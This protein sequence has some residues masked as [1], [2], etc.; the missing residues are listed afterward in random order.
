MLH[1]KN[2]EDQTMKWSR[3]K[4][5]PGL[6]TMNIIHCIQNVLLGTK[7][8][9]G[10]YKYCCVQSSMLEYTVVLVVLAPASVGTDV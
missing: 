9:K 6:P 1:P 4:S 8:C 7:V 3:V 2:W 5:S 10:M